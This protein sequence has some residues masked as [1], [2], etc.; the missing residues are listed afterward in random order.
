MRQMKQMKPNIIIREKTMLKKNAD[1]FLSAGVPVSVVEEICGD[2]SQKQRK[3]YEN[4]LKVQ[5]AILDGMFFNDDGDDAAVGD[6]IVKIGV[7]Q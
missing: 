7:E 5:N 2:V 3:K 4:I 6:V 1:L